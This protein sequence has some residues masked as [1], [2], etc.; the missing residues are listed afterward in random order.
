MIFH[1]SNH[2]VKYNQ[3]RRKDSFLLHHCFFIYF[4]W[5]CKNWSNMVSRKRNVES[6]GNRA[7]NFEFWIEKTRNKKTRRDRSTSLDPIE[8]DPVR[9]LRLLSKL[10]QIYRE[11]VGT[12]RRRWDNASRNIHTFIRWKLFFILIRI[13]LFKDFEISYEILVRFSLFSTP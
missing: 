6:Q 10:G 1:K 7:M 12:N 13:F 5:I 3:Y 9:F 8:E 11:F 4:A 2:Y